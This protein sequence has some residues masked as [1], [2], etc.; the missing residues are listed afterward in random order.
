MHDYGPLHSIAGLNTLQSHLEQKLQSQKAMDK[1]LGTDSMH[2][3]RCHPIP[4]SA[5]QSNYE[6]ELRLKKAPDK[7]KSFRTNSTASDCIPSG[8]LD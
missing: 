1:S 8:S 2:D 5:A 7:D 4:V 6:Q 3:S